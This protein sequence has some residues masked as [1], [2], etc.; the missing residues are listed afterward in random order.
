MAADVSVAV[1][2]R[3]M[4][5]AAA[6]RHL[7]E[8]GVA[9]A[10]IGS[11]EPADYDA[12][13]G[14]FASH[15][16]SGRITRISDADAIWSEMA[17]RSIARYEDIAARSDIAFHRACGLAQTSV[18]A[19]DAVANAV[20]RGGD[21]RAI[22]PDELRETTGI[23][24]RPDHPGTSFYEGPPAGLIDPRR[25]VAAQCRLAEHADAVLVDAPARSV[26]RSAG[27]FEIDCGTTVTS[28]RIVL[29]TGAY[30]ADLVAVELEIERRLRTIVLADLGPGEALPSYIDADPGHDAVDGIY[31]VPPVEYP[32]GRVM[33]KIGGNS[34]PLITAEN[35]ADI[36]A[37]FR[38][39]GSE[40]EAR[41]LQEVLVALLPDAEITAWDHKP[42]VVTN[43]PSGLPFIDVVDE[44]VV[45][46]LGACGAGAKSSDEIGRLAAEL[47]TSGWTDDVLPRDAFRA[48]TA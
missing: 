36:A 2:G 35:Q 22:D 1:V 44:G 43:T 16:D 12:A 14:P 10:L 21:A 40:A 3:G 37:W 48:A 18:T 33:L 6:A 28:D 19:D 29:A 39:G 5:G 20:A 31:W 7:A 32:D 34:T 41:A 9:V 47:A 17:A 24:V 38:A 26:R 25:L 42:C 46:A 8:S 15:Y 27:R 11:G 23:A 45:I 4:V 13:Q 30:G